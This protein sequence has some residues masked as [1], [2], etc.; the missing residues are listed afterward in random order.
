MTREV[1]HVCMLQIQVFVYTLNNA[2]QCIN[3]CLPVQFFTNPVVFF[4]FCFF[5]LFFFCFF[6]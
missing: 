1:S 3:L 4:C 5:F 6:S 2:L